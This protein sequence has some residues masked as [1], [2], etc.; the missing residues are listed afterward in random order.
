MYR[1]LISQ[2]YYST[3]EGVVVLLL[4]LESYLGSLLV[5]R[6]FARAI[7]YIVDSRLLKQPSCVTMPF[8][9]NYHFNVLLDQA[10]LYG[11]HDW[12]WNFTVALPVVLGLVYSFVLMDARDRCKATPR[13]QRKQG[14]RN[15]WILCLSYISLLSLNA[16]KEFRFLLPILPLSCLIAG[17]QVSDLFRGSNKSN[18]FWRLIFCGI[19]MIVPNLLALIYL[20]LFHQQ[21]PVAVNRW[22]VQ[23]ALRQHHR[24]TTTSTDMIRHVHYL[25]GGCHS[26][27]LHSHLHALPVQFVTYTLDCSPSCRADPELDCQTDKFHKDPLAF[28]QEQGYELVRTAEPKAPTHNECT[29]ESHENQTCLDTHLLETTMTAKA[30]T[31]DYVITMS[32]YV[33]SLKASLGLREVARFP[34]RINGASLF[35]MD[36]GDD[37]SGS[38][39]HVT[40]IPAWFE[41]SLDDMVVLVMT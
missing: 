33:D 37:F 6:I 38:F 1:L 18:R 30:V 32:S 9:G 21:G 34:H 35:G 15:L 41:I 8:L 24:R 17:Q 23:D 29:A 36:I 25:T 5:G 11:S 31:V 13:H 7:C 4:L 14:Y 12:H 3:L 20:G 40:I 27:P 26:T 28:L 10:T 22:I 16:H 19:F 39:R 2:K